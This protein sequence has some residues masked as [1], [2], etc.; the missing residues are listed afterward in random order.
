MLTSIEPF[1]FVACSQLYSIKNVTAGGSDKFT[2]EIHIHG[3]PCLYQ[4]AVSRT[5]IWYAMHN[6]V[7]YM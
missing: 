4:F 1:L 5:W 2:I 3:L 7:N 6:M